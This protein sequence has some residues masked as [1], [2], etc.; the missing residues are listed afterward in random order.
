[1]TD[2][3]QLASVI[4]RE[5]AHVLAPPLARLQRR[6][7]RRRQRR[8][9][10]IF[11]TL[12]LAALPVAINMNQG[13]GAARLAGTGTS[14]MYTLDVYPQAKQGDAVRTEDLRVAGEP[15]LH[16]T[17]VAAHVTTDA[18]GYPIIQCTLDEPS[19][20]EFST[21]QPGLI[22]AMVVHGQLLQAP[23]LTERITTGVVELAPRIPAADEGNG[24]PSKIA[25]IKGRYVTLAHQ[26]TDNVTVD[27]T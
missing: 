5:A 6:S 4:D 21:I 24:T 10:A 18:A 3:N 15:V 11:I 19:R 25:D 26:L 22:E 16:L 1:M 2:L 9:T 14:P 27:P 13:G 23:Q 12:T 20:R 7:R 8:T 17:V